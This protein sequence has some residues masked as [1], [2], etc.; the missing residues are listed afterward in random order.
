MR[1][2]NSYRSFLFGF[3]KDPAGLL[4][5]HM[6]PA[7]FAMVDGRDSI[8]QALFLLLS[9]APGERVMRPTFGCDLHRLVFLP[10]DDTTAGLAMHYV[11]QA[12]ERWEARVEVLRV[13][14]G[15]RRANANASAG[16][17]LDDSTVDRLYVTM[18]YRLRQ[19][20]QPDRVMV[21]VDLS[22]GRV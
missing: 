10:N 16:R 5:L 6:T 19:T 13:D 1:T 20:S 22:G 14:A 11:R 21:S 9:T 2:T 18:D 15:R 17:Q 7:G 3:G 8:R 12:V 4:G